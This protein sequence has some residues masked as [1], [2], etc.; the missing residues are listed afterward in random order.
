MHFCSFDIRLPLWK[1]ELSGMAKLPYYLGCPLWASPE[2][3][4]TLFT[5]NAQRTDYLSQYGSVFNTVEGNAT[6]Y[7]LPKTQTVK[8]WADEAPESFRFCFKFSNTISHDKR[9]RYADRETVALFRLL[10]PLQGKLG[11]LFLQLSPYFDAT[12]FADLEKYLKSLPRDFQYAVEVRHSDYFDKNNHELKLDEL[13]R[14]LAMD[15]VLFDTRHL[16]A[17]K[18]TD[19][20]TRNAQKRKPK[21]PHRTTVTGRRP[22]L[23]YVGPS[24]PEDNREALQPWAA[25][26]A[27]WLKQGLT[28]YVFMHAPDDTITPEFCRLFHELL[29]E[30]DPDIAP[31]PPYPGETE[32]E[33]QLT[34]F[35]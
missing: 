29:M 33:A 26:T 7:G 6:F 9:L 21:V 2:W 4:G 27:E 28:P 30:Q 35:D 1:Y 17:A 34:L 5:R 14:K 19:E 20:K 11:P 22:F 24:N 8:R 25:Q 23:R 13:L 15:R 10:E 31:L 18:A 12:S 16:L 32:S 3:R